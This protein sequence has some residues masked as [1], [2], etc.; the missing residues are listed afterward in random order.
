MHRTVHRRKNV[1][2]LNSKKHVFNVFFK[3]P[4]IL[5]MKNV[6]NNSRISSYNNMQRI[7]VFLLSLAEQLLKIILTYT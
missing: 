3:F 7:N 2:N 6:A 4:N 5:L 1:Y